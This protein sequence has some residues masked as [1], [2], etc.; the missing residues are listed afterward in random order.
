[1]IV[2]IIMFNYKNNNYITVLLCIEGEIIYLFYTKI[3]LYTIYKFIS[4]IN[5]QDNNKNKQI[6]PFTRI[7]EIIFL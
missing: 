7:I 2:I 3:Y 1:M 6:V 4:P 5:Y